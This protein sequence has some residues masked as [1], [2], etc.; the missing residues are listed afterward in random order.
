L[1][2]RHPFLLSVLT[3]LL[4]FAAWPVSPLTFLIFIAFIPLLWLER[5]GIRRRK[6]FG[7]V[8]LSMV[9][10]NA[11]TTWWIWNAS[12]PGAVGAIL[13]NSLLMCIP[14]LGF[15][16]VKRRLGDTAGYLSL[17]LFWLGF[18][19]IHLSN[20]G[21]SWPWLT[22]GN[23]F[24]THPGWVQWYEYTG[25]S[26]GGLWIMTV[27]I[28][29]FRLTW[30]KFKGGRFNRRFAIY[31]LLALAL[32]FALSALVLLS[33]IRTV[34]PH[35][36]N[37]IV[38]VQ[39]NIDPYEKLYTGSFEAQLQKL[40]RLSDSA[41][42]DNT[43]LVVW[44][45]T[46]LY[47]ERGFIEDSLRQDFFLNPLWSF[48]HRHPNL[49]L[50]SG[51]ESIRLFN[52]RHSPSAQKI[53]NSD[54]YYESYNAAVLFDSTGP[55]AF[56][57]KSRLVP[58]V[59]TLPPFLHILDS[60][61]EKFGGTTAGYTGQDD[62]SVLNTT[63]HSYHIAPAVCYESIYG[64]FMS[65]Y[66]RNGANII[67]VITNDGWWG[68][69]PG[70]SQ[71]ESYA[72]LRAIETRRWVIRSANTGVSCVIDPDGNIIESS[73]WVQTAVIKKYVPARNDLTFYVRYG[74]CISILAL[75]LTGLLLAWTIITFIKTRNS[76]G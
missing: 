14:W 22:L 29:L 4:L 49:N 71:H 44:P 15:H 38:I 34:V 55:T 2:K 24:A 25:T 74:D 48:L 60:W 20:W 45:E 27:N 69:T 28:L 54:R 12:A 31:S 76:R 73:P 50:L 57:H 30:K 40:I 68:N 6:F 33:S 63:N 9:I 43:V 42:D 3:G 75:I 47:N 52:H 21:L 64:E 17:V 18:E 56:Y 5:Q 41:I 70:Y 58:G 39:P 7:W 16:A 26:G 67:A 51:L 13:A 37:N 35:Q 32:P 19:F 46:A 61:F 10:W 72:R 53:P 59:E 8:Y 66:V 62:R 23:V 11:A 65:R 1:K 36:N